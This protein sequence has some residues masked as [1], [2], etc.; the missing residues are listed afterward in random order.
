MAAGRVEAVLTVVLGFG[1]AHLGSRPEK[2]AWPP[3]STQ[4][5]R[6]ARAPR[7][8]AWTS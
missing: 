5:N 1:C 3:A 2:P 7:S 8:T 6:S 4:W